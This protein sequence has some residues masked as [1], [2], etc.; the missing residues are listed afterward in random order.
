[1][2]RY[3][4]YANGGEKVGMGHLFRIKNLIE[5]LSIKNESKVLYRN[6]TQK[7]FF[8]KRGF[9]THPLDDLLKNIEF[10]YFFLDTKEDLSTEI[11]KLHLPKEKLFIID[12]Y[13]DTRFYCKTEIYPSYYFSNDVDSINSKRILK[14]HNY[15]ILDKNYFSLSHKKKE[16][17]NKVLISF[18][19]EDPNNLTLKCI[20]L[21]RDEE[22]L[23]KIVIVLG[24]NYKH[25]QNLLEKYVSKKNILKDPKNL[26]TLF[27]ESIFVI[28]SLGVT[29][30]ELFKVNTPF[31]LIENYLEDRK[32]EKDIKKSNDKFMGPNFCYFCGFYKDLNKDKLKEGIQ[33]IKKYDFSPNISLEEVGKG[34]SKENLGIN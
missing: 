10:D 6:N 4:F 34:W 21:L 5:N 14:G 12:N 18:G 8:S 29:I 28:T 25:D 16:D 23:E 9:V 1:M 11:K 32:E 24:P 26:E 30:Q 13:T 3:L 15:C 20:S 22:I 2:P 31:I 17:R 7:N 27:S 19:G 33:I